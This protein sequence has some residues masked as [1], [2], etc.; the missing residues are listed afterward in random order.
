MLLSNRGYKSITQCV[1]GKEALDLILN[2]KGIDYYDVIF[3]DNMMP[4]MVIYI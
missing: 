3:L 2:E 4:I 1:D